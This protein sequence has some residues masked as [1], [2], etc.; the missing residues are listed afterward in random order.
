MIDIV[1]KTEL[2]LDKALLQKIAS[3]YTKKDIEL[4]V[5]DNAEIRQINRSYRNINKATDV[6]SFPLRGKKNVLL[7]TIVISSDYVQKAAKEFGH[8]PK[9]ELT[10]LFIHGLLHLLGYDHEKDN[11]EMRKE[12]EKLIKRFDLPRSLIIRND[13]VY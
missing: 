9:D 4:I 8:V 13:D 2:S 10:L 6:L 11:G 12:E 5:T 3:L 1:N 7:G